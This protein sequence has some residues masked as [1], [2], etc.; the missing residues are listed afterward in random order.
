MAERSGLLNRRTPKV[1]PGFESL[2]LR[3]FITMQIP[4]RVQTF[5][6]KVLE[7]LKTEESK[8]IFAALPFY[9][10]WVPILSFNDQIL[11]IRKVCLYSAINTGLFFSLLFIAQIFSLF[12]FIGS[13]LSNFLHLVSILLYLG[14]SG[15]LIYSLRLKKTI[16]IPILSDWEKKLSSLFAPIAQL[17]RVSDYG[18][19]G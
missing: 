2:R 12:P 19:E 18:S 13:F 10:S 3:Y 1:Y 16:D 7:V 17:D 14:L 5:A 11:K 9:F 8:M 4:P 6:K 15:F